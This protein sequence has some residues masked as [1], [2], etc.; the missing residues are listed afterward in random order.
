MEDQFTIQVN[1]KIGTKL[2]IIPFT[3]NGTSHYKI[4]SGNLVIAVLVPN[5]IQWYQV[6]GALDQAIIDEIGNAIE[7]YYL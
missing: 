3:Q 1:H 7:C 5:E 4:M 2:V 6:E